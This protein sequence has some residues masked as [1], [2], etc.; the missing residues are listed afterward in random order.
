[1]AVVYSRFER[2][3]QGRYRSICVK[4]GRVMFSPALHTY[5]LDCR[6][7]MRRDANG[8]DGELSQALVNSK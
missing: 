3:C 2:E 5:C 1:M 8:S 4:C 6:L 7:K